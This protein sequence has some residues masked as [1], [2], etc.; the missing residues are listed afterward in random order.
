LL[1][2][3]VVCAITTVLLLL[4][5]LGARSA[6]ADLTFTVSVDTSPLSGQSGY[7][8]LQF[9]PGDSSA[10]FATATVTLFQTSGGILAQPAALTG[11]AAGSLPGAL[12]LDNGTVYND[13]F[14]GFTFGS[15]FGLTLT[16]SGPAIDNPGGTAGSAFALSLYASDGVTPL[17]TTDP[18]GSVATVFLNPNG[19]ASAETFARSQTESTPAAIVTAVNAV[20][21]PSTLTLALV[22]TLLQVSMFL[23]RRALRGP[24][25][26]RITHSCGA[27]LSGT[28]PA[29]VF[30]RSSNSTLRPVQQ[31]ANAT[32]V[33]PSFNTIYHFDG[34]VMRPMNRM[35]P[36]RL[37]RIRNMNG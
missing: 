3:L 30:P 15:S 6:N 20:P 26:G 33:S 9:N 5:D 4:G 34:S 1:K 29:R 7:L 22:F 10:E 8:D 19:T 14:Q 27:K 23:V 13:I 31:F 25:A 2:R 28:P 17:L 18:N 21:E 35:P 24:T 16:L 32:F 36:E 37:S 11:D 12:T